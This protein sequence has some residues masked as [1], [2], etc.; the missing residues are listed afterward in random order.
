MSETLPRLSGSDLD[1]AI[2]NALLKLKPMHRKFAELYATGTLSAAE[3]SIQA[4][5]SEKSAGKNS[6]RLTKNEG[7]AL[8]CTLL[9]EKY[10]YENGIPAKRIRHGLIGIAE[11]ESTPQTVRVQAY[12]KLI[13]LDHRHD[14]AQVQINLG[15]NTKDISP[16][17]LEK[18][19]QIGEVLE[20]KP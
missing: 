5:Y 9:A 13:D 8:A 1:V 4:G 3:A 20:H 2:K 18:L 16:A 12:G 11:D 6:T 7:I 10:S 17:D 19:A 14:Q 15:D